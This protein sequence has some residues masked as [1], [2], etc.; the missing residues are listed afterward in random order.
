VAHARRR[1]AA[2]GRADLSSPRHWICSQLGAREHYA[3]PRALHQ[4]GRLRLLITDAWI[5][6]G[7]PIGHVPIDIA[8]RL[9]ERSHP[10]LPSDHV[11][12][13]TLSLL[14][15]EVEWR[16]QR[17]ADWDLVM[18]RNEWF[19][20]E[21]AAVVRSLPVP[22]NRPMALF[23]HSYSARE[24]LRAAKARGWVTVLGQIDAGEEHFAIARRLAEQWPQYGPV[25]PVPPNSYFESWRE[26]CALADHVVVN[27]DWTRDAL[28]MAGIDAA[29]V[30]VVPLPFDADR[31]DSAARSFPDR[32]TRERPLRL[33]FVGSVS[34]IKGAPQLLDAMALLA[35]LPVTLRLVGAPGMVIP[36]AARRLPGVE[37]VDA[38]PRGEI[39]KYYD[40]SDVL[41]FPSHSDGFG[42]VQIEAQ[43]RGLPLIASRHCGRVVE[44]GVNGILLTEVTADAISTAV[45]RLLDQPSLVK[46]QSQHAAAGEGASLQG[47]GAV[48]IGMAGE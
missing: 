35:D 13:L 33:L 46:S 20:R 28:S 47:F 30:G 15:Q 42:L 29:K 9:A 2:P 6:P 44:D 32:F 7:N 1:A 18:A 37:F 43:A 36:D 22:A 48:L 26:E 19:M 10:D 12:D 45:R 25:P 16:L 41:V 3:A 8:R 34:V 24:V 38:V 21:A 31:P 5:R 27:S 17:R 14:A 11:H 23:A 40:S 4:A 39:G